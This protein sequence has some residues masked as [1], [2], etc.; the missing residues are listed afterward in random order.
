MFWAKK[1]QEGACTVRVSDPRWRHFKVSW[2]AS[3]YDITLLDS[4]I[5]GWVV[6][7]RKNGYAQLIIYWN[8]GNTIEGW[9]PIS[10]LE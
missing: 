7:E 2:D 3:Y 9:V 5:E 4:L 10:Y 8:Q 1:L 6:K